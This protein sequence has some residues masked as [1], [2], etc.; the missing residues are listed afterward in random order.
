[1][2]MYRCRACGRIITEEQYLE[3]QEGGSGGH[4]LCEFSD[5]NRILNE[6]VEA[7]WWEI[8]DWNQMK[9]AWILLSDEL[10]KKVRDA[11][12]APDYD[13]QSLGAED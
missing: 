5:G 8:L 11:G 6:M 12:L 13:A 7:K 1:M 10:K 2:K 9:N 3:E 4:C